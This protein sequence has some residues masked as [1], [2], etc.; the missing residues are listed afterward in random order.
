MESD[1]HERDLKTYCDLK[2]VIDT[3]FDDGRHKA[4]IDIAKNLKSLGVGPDVII[5][6]TGLTQIELD[7]L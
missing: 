1:L 4:K 5:R 2:R 6:S 3:A 7:N